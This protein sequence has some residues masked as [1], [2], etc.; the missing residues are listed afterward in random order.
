VTIDA[1]SFGAKPVPASAGKRRTIQHLLSLAQAQ[2][3]RINEE[4]HRQAERER[5]RRLKALAEKEAQVWEQVRA[6]ISQK[7]AKGYDEAVKH[8][9]ELRELA[10]YERKTDEFTARIRQ[11]QE[12]FPTL[13]GLKSRLRD[14]GL[15]AGRR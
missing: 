5:V 6:L 1:G 12:D 15:I 7:T 3:K 8:L 11:I 13:T 14:A 10:Q 9:K 4:I 2:Q